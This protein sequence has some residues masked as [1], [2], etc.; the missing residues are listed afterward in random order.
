MILYFFVAT[1]LLPSIGTDLL[2]CGWCLLMVDTLSIVL[3]YFISL[4]NF[5]FL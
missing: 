4:M 5:C 1:L 3:Y 2:Q